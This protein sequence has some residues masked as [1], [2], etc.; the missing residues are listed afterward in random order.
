MS[1]LGVAQDDRHLYMMLDYMPQGELFKLLERYTRFTPQLA[2]FY[3][4]QVTLFFQHIHSRGLIYR[5][6]KPENI[7]M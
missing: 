7:L 1:L 4:A 6:L 5:D 3:I 2:A